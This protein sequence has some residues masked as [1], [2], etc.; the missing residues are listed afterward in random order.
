M[1]EWQPIETAP[2]SE[3]LI[4]WFPLPGG[5]TSHARVHVMYWTNWDGLRGFIPCWNVT[6]WGAGMDALFKYQPTHWMPLPDPPRS[7]P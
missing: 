6:G 1:S 3:R 7:Q 4:G 5:T 2:K